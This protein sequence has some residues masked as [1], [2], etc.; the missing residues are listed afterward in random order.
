MK[1]N[2]LIYTSLLDVEVKSWDLLWDLM[3][4]QNVNIFVFMGHRLT[5]EHY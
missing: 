2:V 5:A 4:L 1:Y 3:W